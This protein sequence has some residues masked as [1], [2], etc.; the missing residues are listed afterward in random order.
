[1]LNNNISINPNNNLSSNVVNKPKVNTEIPFSPVDPKRVT[2]TPRE[3]AHSQVKQDLFH[4]HP[5]S[6]FQRFI[7]SLQNSPILSEAAKKLLLNK[8]FINSNIVRDPLLKGIFETFLNSIEMDDREM[9]NFLK[10]QQESY[11]KFQGDF[12]Q[13]LRNILVNNPNNKDFKILLRN[14]LRTYDCYVS[15]EETN[16]S[17]SSA[18]KNIERNIPEILRNPL[19]EMTEKLVFIRQSAETD[20]D[21]LKNEILPFIGRYISKMNDFGVVRD[22]VSLL[23]HNLIRLEYALESNFSY[24]LENLLEYIKYNFNMEDKEVESLKMS[25]INT[26]EKASTAKNTSM[27]SFLT[28][29]KKGALDSEN[30]VTKALMGEMTDSLLFS[31]N[32]NIPL[33]H[34]FLPLNYKGMFMFSE[35][36]IGKE[37]NEGN[38][39]KSPMDYEPAYKVFITFDIQNLGYFESVLKLRGTKLSLNVSVPTTLSSYREKIKK[40]LAEILIKN[41]II[42]EDV[43][44]EECIKVRKFNE[45]FSNLAERK[46]IVDV[47][48]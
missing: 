44:V 42:V 14:F 24:D 26:F 6:V 13:E 19:R 34:M 1:M 7:K 3:E 45:V 16:K 12:F 33:M 38:K 36:W 47:T 11:T 9:L 10:F 2:Q 32:I 21:I 8:Q 28:L 46:K 23:V 31:Q 30:P 40:D 39:K 29:I 5:D 27:E 25:L 4:Y 22:Y 35:I 20:L 48:I 15:L 41:G 17:I 37:E 43:S 18:L